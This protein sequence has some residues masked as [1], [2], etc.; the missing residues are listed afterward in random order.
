MSHVSVVFEVKRQKEVL[1]SKAAWLVKKGESA[2]VTAD[3]L[4]RGRRLQFTKPNPLTHLSSIYVKQNSN[5][6]ALG[7]FL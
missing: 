2:G 3:L 7:N 4:L 1:G 6:A 5:F